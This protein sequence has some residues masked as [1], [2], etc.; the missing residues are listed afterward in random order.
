MTQVRDGGEEDSNLIIRA[1]GLNLP[2]P[3]TSSGNQLYVLFHSD[4]SVSRPGFTATYQV[5]E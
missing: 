3:I 2:E 1:C 5:G 4:Y